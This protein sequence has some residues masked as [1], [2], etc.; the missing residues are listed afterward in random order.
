MTRTTTTNSLSMNSS[1]SWDKKN[2]KW[3]A[4]ITVDS[5]SHNL[6]RY[7]DDV[8]AAEVY[9]RAAKETFGRFAL[10]NF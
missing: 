3:I 2:K 7:H 9:D 5:K 1:T 6:G 4:F 10:T 8:E